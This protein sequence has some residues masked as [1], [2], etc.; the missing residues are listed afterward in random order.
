MAE[1]PLIQELQAEVVHELIADLLKDRF[2]ELPADL[3]R[4]LRAIR[5]LKVLRK[6]HL[7]AA[8]CPDLDAFRK[9]LPTA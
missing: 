4:Q 7:V 5:K 2:K 9:S 8:K 1:L 3:N 6:L